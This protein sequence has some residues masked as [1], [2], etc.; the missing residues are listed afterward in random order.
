MYPSG[1]ANWLTVVQV[2]LHTLDVTSNFISELENISHLKEL[3][4]LW[5]GFRA[6]D[7]TY[8]HLADHATDKP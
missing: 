4:E 2:K 8:S 5:V 3:E 7:F 6:Q 1:F